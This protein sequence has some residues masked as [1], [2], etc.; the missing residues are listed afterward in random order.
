MPGL[1]LGSFLV[2]A[3]YWNN[4]KAL[5]WV[6]VPTGE[7]QSTSVLTSTKSWEFLGCQAYPFAGSMPSYPFLLS[8]VPK[9]HFKR[10]FSGDVNS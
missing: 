4:S 3:I 9:S 6:R 10:D 2:V 1:D 7:V 5:P 8:A